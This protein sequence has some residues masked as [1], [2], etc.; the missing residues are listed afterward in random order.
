MPRRAG[1]DKAQL[2]RIIGA[3]L[4]VITRDQAIAC[5]LTRSMIADR[6]GPNGSWRSILP[7]V[8]L[9][10]TGE[11]TRPQREMA[12]LLYAGPGSMVTGSHAV[13]VQ[14]V[15]CDVPE[16]ILVLVAEGCRRTSTGFVRLL[17]TT[18]MPT[19]KVM[20][21]PIRYAPLP[22]AICDTAREMRRFGDVQTLV[23]RAIQRGL[24]SPEELERELRDGPIRGSQLLR[25]AVGEVK[26][27]IW[28]APEGDLK[29]LID[30]SDLEKPVYNPMLYTKDKKFIGCPDAWWE[31]AGVAA[32]VDSYQYHFEAKDYADTVD[33]RNRMT[34]VGINV[35]QF[36][37]KKIKEHGPEVISDLRKAISDGHKRPKLPIHTERTTP[38]RV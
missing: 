37:P 14:G 6:I 23:C 33:K 22:R 8:Y 9:T 34:L 7:S 29:R 11:P 26:S 17:R 10:V 3:Q 31:R 25:E 32:E 21:G 5:K 30:R 27:G 19:A 4:G 1:Y 16:V 15:K 36:L 28:S 12:A 24:C 35:R 18:R 2:R 13:E 20:A 38:R